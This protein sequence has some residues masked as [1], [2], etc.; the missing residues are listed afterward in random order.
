MHRAT[1]IARDQKVAG[2]IAQ[3]SEVV[4]GTHT[5]QAIGDSQSSCHTPSA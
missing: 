5:S 3:C 1:R 4:I 2:V